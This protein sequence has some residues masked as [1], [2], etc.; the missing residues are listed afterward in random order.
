MTT[1][2]TPNAVRMASEHL[3]AIANLIERPPLDDVKLTQSVASQMATAIRTVLVALDAPAK[4]VWRCYH[5]DETFNDARCARLHFGRDE[6]SL[7]ACRIK[8][9]AEQGLLGALRDA[10]Y[11]AADA[12]HAIADES[13]DAAKAYYAQAS[14]HD[15][16]L[17]AAEEAGYERGIADAHVLNK[18]QAVGAEAIFE[19]VTARSH[20]SVATAWTCGLAATTLAWMLR[21]VRLSP[22]VMTDTIRGVGHMWVEMDGRYYD[23][24]IAQF[25]DFADHGPLP[26]PLSATPTAADEHAD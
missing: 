2:P 20:P 9:G 7:P 11:A 10:E 21:V 25:G 4:P 12:R 1:Q 24:T 18:D 26:H 23:P 22:V 8:A 19:W 16:A 6:D 5:C 3:T 17:K 14:R 13:T 15:R